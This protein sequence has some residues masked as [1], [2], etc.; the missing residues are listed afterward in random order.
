MN[1]VQQNLSFI[2]LHFQKPSS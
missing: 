1:E 2:I